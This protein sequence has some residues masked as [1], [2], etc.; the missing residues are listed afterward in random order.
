MANAREELRVQ[1][2]SYTCSHNCMGFRGSSGGCC[3]LDD[4]AF[5]PGPVRDADAFLADLGRLL[6]REVSR[7]EAFIDFEEG[8]ALFRSANVARTR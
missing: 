5:I 1:V 8:R 6:G 3:T 7:D 2:I 4:R